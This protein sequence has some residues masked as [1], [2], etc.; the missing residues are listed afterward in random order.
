[1][2]LALLVGGNNGNS[3]ILSSPELY[4]ER[5]SLILYSTLELAAVAPSKTALFPFL[6]RDLPEHSYFMMYMNM[7]WSNAI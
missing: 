4:I 1:M 5:G 7:V 2:L 6:Y 3:S